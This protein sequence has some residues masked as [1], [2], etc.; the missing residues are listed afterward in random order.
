MSRPPEPPH[1]S[2]TIQSLYARM[3]ASPRSRSAISENVCPQKR[4]KLDGKHIIASM[5]PSSMS[6]SRATGS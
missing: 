5:P 2:S 3:H 6:T 4:G 1:H